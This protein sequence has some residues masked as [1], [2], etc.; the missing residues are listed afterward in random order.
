[1]KV[2]DQ[3]YTGHI[4]DMKSK[5]EA[6]KAKS[7]QL[8][9]DSINSGT[10]TYYFDSKRCQSDELVKVENKVETIIKRDSAE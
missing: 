1:M 6:M 10:L 8:I 7:N 5:L 9:K 4:Q 3:N 2:T